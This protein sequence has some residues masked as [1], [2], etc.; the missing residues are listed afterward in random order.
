MFKLKNKQLLF[1]V[2]SNEDNVKLWDITSVERCDNLI[3]SYKPFKQ[4][5]EST[6]FVRN[7]EYKYLQIKSINLCLR[8]DHNPW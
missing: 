7:S 1:N 8:L 6:T 4:E 3:N 5:K 2:H